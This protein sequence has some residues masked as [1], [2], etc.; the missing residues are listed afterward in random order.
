[1]H[2]RPL[3]NA[4]GALALGGAAL[5]AVAAPAAAEP[6]PT[7]STGDVGIQ[8][9]SHPFSN[10]DARSGPFFDGNGINIRPGPHTSCNPVRG[11]GQASHNV[12]YWCWTSGDSVTNSAGE[13]WSTWTYMV[14]TS[15]GIR[16]WVSDALLDFRDGTRGSN[17][18]CG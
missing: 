1:M 9:C 3:A 14:D 8:S 4:A 10:L 6:K 15:T 2:V 12:D 18:F 11:Q 16:G 13:T 7:G 17:H 5:L